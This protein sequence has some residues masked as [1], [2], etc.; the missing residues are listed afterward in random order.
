MQLNLHTNNTP[1]PNESLLIQN[2]LYTFTKV[3]SVE[4]AHMK[5]TTIINKLYNK[6]LLYNNNIIT[7]DTQIK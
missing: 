1:R 5:K 3:L 2:Y 7:T 6:L 4:F